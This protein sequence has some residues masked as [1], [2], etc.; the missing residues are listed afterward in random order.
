MRCTRCRGLMVG[1]FFV[2]R[3]NEGHEGLSPWRCVNCGELVDRRVLNNRMASRALLVEVAAFH[4][5]K[6]HHVFGR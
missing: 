4:P 6:L 3:A 5:R 2:D 1:E